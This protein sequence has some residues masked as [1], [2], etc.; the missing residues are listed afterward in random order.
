MRDDY[1]EQATSGI[2]APSF[3]VNARYMLINGQRLHD[4][5]AV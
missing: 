4:I 5:F 1:T 2:S 3:H